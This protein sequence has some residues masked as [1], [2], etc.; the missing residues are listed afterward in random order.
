VYAHDPEELRKVTRHPKY[1]TELCKKYHSGEICLYG[2]RCR[3][4]HDLNE[5]EGGLGKILK[6]WNDAYDND[7][8]SDV[9]KLF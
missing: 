6:I 8:H 7:V 3:F 5:S 2:V 9:Y 4:I 1:K